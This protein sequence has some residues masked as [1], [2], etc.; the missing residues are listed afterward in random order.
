MLEFIKEKGS[1]AE[2]VRASS[3]AVVLYG[4]G[5]GADRI[6]AWCERER[7]PVRGIFASDEFVRGQEFHGMPV[8]RYAD[9]KKRLG[10]DLLIL[11]AFASER[12]EVLA[13][14]RALAADE[15]VLA[16]HLPLFEEEETVDA[17][18]LAKYER[19]LRCVYERL[20]DDASRRVFANVLN[21]KLSGKISYL[22]ACETHREDDMRE[23]L[24][25]GEDETYLD[26]GAYDGDTV[27]ELARLTGWRWRKVLAVEPDRRNCRK[28]RRTADELAARDLPVEVFERGIWKEE[29]ELLFSDS[30]G[31]AA[32]FV[33]AEKLPV[34]VTTIDALAA[35]EKITYIKMDVE[36]AEKEALAGGARTISECKPKLFIAA[37]HYDADI[38][39]LPLF[40]WELVP[41]YKI[42]LRK[43]PYVPAWEMNFLCIA[44]GRGTQNVPSGQK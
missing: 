20:A 13:R 16:P 23:L 33:G 21:Y 27:R 43:H 1:I 37:Y 5:D 10:E 36:G 40:L 28:L 38:F 30:G 25:L 4:M 22:F 19:E 29:G 32:T 17:A 31:R 11:I 12:E 7:I 3:R 15:E 42:Y 26:L 24:A 2:H 6:L 8:E 41:E 14:F 18:W 39:R 9:L 34:R 44:Q 35:G